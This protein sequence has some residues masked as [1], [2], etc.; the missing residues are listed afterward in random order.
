MEGCRHVEGHLHKCRQVA[1]WVG[2]FSVCAHLDLAIE[3]MYSHDDAG[4]KPF[5]GTEGDSKTLN[6]HKEESERR[7]KMDETGRNKIAV[8]LQKHSHPLNVK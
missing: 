5:G 3:A 6:K 1:V 2:S 7:R 4:G 8:E